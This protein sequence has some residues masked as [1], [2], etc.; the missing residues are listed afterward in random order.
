MGSYRFDPQEHHGVC[1]HEL[2]LPQHHPMTGL[3]ESTLANRGPHLGRH[4]FTTLPF[5]NVE[6][7]SYH[8]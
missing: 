6:T 1:L 5:M 2:N 4:S 7:R 3:Q 8:S